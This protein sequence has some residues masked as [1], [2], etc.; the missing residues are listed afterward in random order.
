MFW[1]KEIGDQ[2][3]HSIM[4][5]KS[6]ALLE[7]DTVLSSASSLCHAEPR[8][9]DNADR[10]GRHTSKLPCL[11]LAGDHFMGISK[12]SLFYFP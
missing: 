3:P 5:H 2:S 11:A 4:T 9:N 1:R 8:S 7:L 6:G 10:G 12:V